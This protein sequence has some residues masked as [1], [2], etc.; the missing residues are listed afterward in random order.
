[1][2]IMTEPRPCPCGSVTDE[3]CP[4]DETTRGT[5]LGWHQRAQDGTPTDQDLAARALIHPPT[6]GHQPDA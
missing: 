6:V 2:E 3:E 4:C 5:I 1:M